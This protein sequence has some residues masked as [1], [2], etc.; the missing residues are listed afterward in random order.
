MRY[1]NVDVVFSETRW[2]VIIKVYKN[3]VL[4]EEF[5]ASADSLFTHREGGIWFGTRKEYEEVL[6]EE[7]NWNI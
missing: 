4:I 2:D 1:E 6:D 7:L 5:V 3:G